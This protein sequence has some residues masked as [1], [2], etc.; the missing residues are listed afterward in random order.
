MS[1][2][3]MR[4][5]I[6]F[7]GLACAGL[8]SGA[9]SS[10]NDNNSADGGGNH[11]G[12]GGSGGGSGSSG[13]CTGVAPTSAT[14]TDFSDAV[15]DPNTAGSFRIGTPAIGGTYAYGGAMTALASG[16]LHVTGTIAA[17][18]Y[19]GAGIYFDNCTNA[20]SYTGVQ[21]TLTG[22]L[23]TCDMFKFGANFPETDVMTAG[24]HGICPA[25]ATTCY[26]PGSPYTATT[27]MVTFAS[28][29]GGGAVPTVTSDEQTRLTG[30]GWGFHATDSCTVDFTI[31]NVKFY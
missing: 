25:T 28:M 31:D 21:F 14:I 17:G 5:F 3:R 2:L 7:A 1:G 26:G 15:A 12:S 30:V 19:A 27:T 16:A 11:G 9:C 20:A 29:S 18:T 8:L 22:S 13:V 10:S 24:G 23:G 4:A 6:G